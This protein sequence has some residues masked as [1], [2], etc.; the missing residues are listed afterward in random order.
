MNRNRMEFKQALPVNETPRK[1]NT[2]PCHVW[3][4]CPIQ[5]CFNRSERKSTQLLILVFVISFLPCRK[6]QDYGFFQVSPYQGLTSLLWVEGG[7]GG[8]QRAIHYT[9]ICHLVSSDH[10]YECHQNI[11]DFQ[12]P[13][14][15][16]VKKSK[17]K[18]QLSIKT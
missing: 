13:N 11:H 1:S 9:A 3:C 12:S 2:K 10:I 17:I 6:S 5:S 8:L 15:Y 16:R 18:Q 14:I 4:N 7:N